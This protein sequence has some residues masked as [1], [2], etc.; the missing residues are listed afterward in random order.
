M[1]THPDITPFVRIIDLIHCRTLLPDIVLNKFSHLGKFFSGEISFVIRQELIAHGI[2][3]HIKV[4]CL[5]PL[6]AILTIQ[7]IIQILLI[8]IKSKSNSGFS[9]IFLVGI[10]TCY[11]K[12]QRHVIERAVF[13]RAFDNVGKVCVV[14]KLSKIRRK[15]HK[16]VG[17]AEPSV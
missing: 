5:S 1:I 14:I 10:Y 11:G 17:I 15:V 13:L 6:N 2:E 8:F 9:C 16:T 7:C 4:I 12:A 3:K